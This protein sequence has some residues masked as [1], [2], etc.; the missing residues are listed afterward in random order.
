MGDILQPDGSFITWGEATHRGI[1]PTSEG[2]F[3]ALIGNLKLVPEI[4]PPDMQHDLFVE[5]LD[6]PDKNTVWLFQLPAAHLSERWL[7]FL[8]RTEPKGTFASDG[9]S[10]CSIATRAPSPNTTLRRII[11]RAPHGSQKRFHAGIWQREHLMSAQHIWQDGTVLINSSTSQLRLMQ[12]RNQASL[13][14]A[15]AKWSIQLNRPVPAE[16]WTDT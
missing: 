1:P 16:V 12:V 2:A 14:G 3:H 11:V 15:L 13:H 5:A 4:D 10:I 8:T 7:P 6:G 9:V